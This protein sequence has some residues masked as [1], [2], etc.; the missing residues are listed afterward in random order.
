[1]SHAAEM[2][3]R[4]RMILPL[5]KHRHRHRSYLKY[6]LHTDIHMLSTTPQVGGNAIIIMIIK[7]IKIIII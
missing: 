3:I 7:I 1:M 4:W 6:L 5:L 2:P